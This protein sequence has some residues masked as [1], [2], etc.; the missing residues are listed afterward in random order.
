MKKNAV[1]GMLSGLFVCSAVMLAGAEPLVWSDALNDASRWCGFD[2]IA[3]K[4]SF[5]QKTPAE[6]I[7][8][9]SDSAGVHNGDFRF[10]PLFRLFDM[11]TLNGAEMLSFDICV[12]KGD[13]TEGSVLFD[14]E[15]SVSFTVTK[16]REYQTIHIP[17]KKL[18][19]KLGK[20]RQIQIGF[21]EAI[22]KTAW[23]LRNV[24]VEGSGSGAADLKKIDGNLAM[25]P[26]AP[27]GVFY[28]SEPLKF[29][30]VLPESAQYTIKDIWG[31]TV[32]QGVVNPGGNVLTSLPRGYYF[33]TLH[34]DKRDYANRRR[35][36]VVSDRSVLPEGRESNYSLVLASHMGRSNI[37]F[38][39][40]CT[41]TPGG[42]IHIL[43]E[44]AARA[45]AFT[46]RDHTHWLEPAPGVYEFEEPL[47]IARQL[48]ERGIVLTDMIAGAPRWSFSGKFPI[49]QGLQHDLQLPDDLRHAFN[50]SKALVEHFRGLTK[51]C[52]F[53][54]EPDAHANAAWNYA[55]AMKAAYLGFR[56]GNPDV[57][58]LSG[59]FL[60]YAYPEIAM[61]S[62]M[63]EY[64]DV[65]NF[66]SYTPVVDFD[67]QM[68]DLKK[69]LSDAGAG[70]RP[71]VC[72]ELGTTHLGEP[73]AASY[74]TDIKERND[75][76][77]M[78]YAE[79]V[80]KSQIIMQN[81]GLN[82]GYTFLLPPCADSAPHGV[83]PAD[84]AMMG[85][86]NSAKPALTAFSVLSHELADAEML[87]TYDTVP[88][89]RG[90]LFRR[91][92]G[93]QTLVLW[94][95]SSLETVIGR[96]SYNGADDEPVIISL[97]DGTYRV[98]DIFGTEKT[99]QSQNG[100]LML[101]V[102]RLPLYVS[103]LHGLK[104]AK[105]FH[106][107]QNHVKKRNDLD[108]TI[109]ANIVTGSDM[110]ISGIRLYSELKKPTAEMGLHLYNFSDE[111]KRGTLQFSG[112][113]IDRDFGTVTI[114]PRGR[115][116]LKMNIT[117]EVHPGQP[118]TDVAVN[119][120]FNGKKITPAVMPV[121][122]SDSVIKTKP[123]SGA[124]RASGWQDSKL[125]NMTR[126]DDP[127]NHAVTF[128]GK[129]GRPNGYIYP[130]YVLNKDESLKDAVGLEFEM[131]LDPA[132]GEK[133][134]NDCRVQLVCDGPFPGSKQETVLLLYDAPM[135]GNWKKI[136]VFFAYKVKDPAKIRKVLIGLMPLTTEVEFK[137]RNL[138]M[139]LPGK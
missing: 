54:N 3:G 55:A 62:G 80:V 45:G 59:S 101:Q 79:F 125:C 25:R 117:P 89:M 48:K 73:T 21:R 110:P 6:G 133:G 129:F 90:F 51:Y 77:D 118:F 12:E 11:E 105:E 108:K 100:K 30:A 1:K 91:S 66:H 67:I 43:S 136:R 65:F 29:A 103:G 58:V 71:M 40:F 74:R 93:T 9:E 87:G 8:F 84:W 26:T 14:R 28:E 131:W 33:L 86:D 75:A 46:V 122:I 53:W 107:R 96:V 32:Q 126:S 60:T 50:Y 132:T 24:R 121:L 115:I 39:R 85:F 120:I 97:P 95:I 31:K 119:G 44:L 113:T 63:A 116:E 36:T 57:K 17:L 114:P 20:Y 4:W 78:L 5:L 134:L 128:K 109:V 127:D 61:K 13:M 70:D 68:R 88:G 72:T 135:D 112:G 123:I 124:D 19:E 15:V 69:M 138:K 18:P 56:E 52:E 76:Q 139:L 98:S 130:E 49:P 34:S 27:G 47:V 22:G 106:K 41:V 35:F 10:L 37:R 137:V 111:V 64:F 99:L 102:S 23:Y 94:K 38:N 92:D 81:Y 82:I 42:S 16:K 83:G 7:R 104:P 2:V